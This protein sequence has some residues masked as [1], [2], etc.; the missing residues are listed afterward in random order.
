[1]LNV[2]PRAIFLFLPFLLTACQTYRSHFDCPPGCGIP[3][4]PVT[5]IE[6]MILETDEGPDLFLGYVPD[7]EQNGS[8]GF[9]R[10]PHRPSNNTMR[11][12]LEGKQ[13]PCGTY[14]EGHY[15]FIL[16]DGH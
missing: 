12:W 2:N 16:K 13:L 4:T 5:T 15:I 6:K 14:I 10:L 8:Q 7:E 3:C 9:A 1:M 11:V